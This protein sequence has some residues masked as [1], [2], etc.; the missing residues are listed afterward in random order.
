MCA[1]RRRALA[2]TRRLSC[3]PA[4]AFFAPDGEGVQRRACFPPKAERRPVKRLRAST[5]RAAYTLP[6]DHQRA[7]PPHQSRRENRLWTSISTSVDA[8]NTS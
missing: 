8:L 7:M 1:H 4:L 3:T 5:R 2:G 6:G